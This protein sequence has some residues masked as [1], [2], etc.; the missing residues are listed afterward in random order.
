MDDRQ[1][2]RRKTVCRRCGRRCSSL[3]RFG[4]IGAVA[5]RGALRLSLHQRC[6]RAIGD[7]LPL[8][9]GNGGIDVEHEWIDVGTEFGD[10]EGNALRHQPGDE[11]DIARQAV[12]L[13]D[14]NRASHLSRLRQ[15][16]GEHWTAMEC[17]APLPGLDLDQFGH[18]GVALSVAEAA[19]AVALRF[20]TKTAPA[21][22]LRGYP[23]I[24][25]GCLIVRHDALSPV[26]LQ[27][28]ATRLYVRL[29]LSHR[30]SDSQNC[31]GR[32]FPSA[33]R[34]VDSFDEVLCNVDAAERNSLTRAYPRQCST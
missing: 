21:L 30:L 18:D 24:G 27:R 34:E 17:V 1:D 14:D 9:L 5:E 8:L 16:C 22:A 20:K 15:C 11:V 19:D 13:G 29:A 32:G 10:D 4:Q 7:E 31:R 12:E 3:L 23:Q 33:I 28:V 2:A 26:L 6:P 25:D